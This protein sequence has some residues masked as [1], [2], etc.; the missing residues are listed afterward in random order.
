[1]RMMLSFRRIVNFLKSLLKSNNAMQIIEGSLE[2][3]R[4]HWGTAHV[5]HV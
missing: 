1:M 5:A 3:E 4:N 2:F